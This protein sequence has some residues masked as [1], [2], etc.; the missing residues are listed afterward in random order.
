LYAKLVHLTALGA[1]KSGLPKL[2]QA[3]YIGLL[4]SWFLEQK[5]CNAAKMH[6]SCMWRF[7]DRCTLPLL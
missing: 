1:V 3:G 5:F 4:A 7:A 2:V 6:L